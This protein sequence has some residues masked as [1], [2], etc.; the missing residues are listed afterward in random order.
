MRLGTCKRVDVAA[1]LGNKAKD[2]DHNNSY[3]CL[4][5]LQC[6]QNYARSCANKSRPLSRDTYLCGCL[7]HAGSA[8]SSH[9]SSF[10]GPSSLCPDRGT[11]GPTSH[12]CNNIPL[13]SR[14]LPVTHLQQLDSYRG[15]DK[16]FHTRT[17][18]PPP[19]H[20]PPSPPAPLGHSRK[21]KMYRSRRS[22]ADERGGI[23]LKTGCRPPGPLS[24]LAAWV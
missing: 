6:C 18:P 2:V 9:T 7:S 4:L 10:L 5:L 12:A 19:P 13:C 17:E 16:W 11:L 14:H 8:A 23:H 22:G 1:Q 21:Q 24:L 20:Q 3:S 15:I